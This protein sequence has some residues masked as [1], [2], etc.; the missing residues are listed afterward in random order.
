MSELP[1]DFEVGGDTFAVRT[2]AVKDGRL[3]SIT[4]GSG[5]WNDGRC[6]A[7]C[8]VHPDDPDHMVPSEDCTCGIYAWWRPEQLLDQYEDHAKR[9][10]AV[11]R[12]EGA[13]I[14]GD[15]GVKS[16]AAEIVAWWVADCDDTAMLAAACE[17]SAPGAR[18]FFDRDVMTGLHPTGRSHTNG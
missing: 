6:L 7:I 13:C 11:I 2:F 9:V 5:H 18:R 16:N 17:A 15:R 3:T 4:H 12:M 1:T 8:T 10:I 14:E